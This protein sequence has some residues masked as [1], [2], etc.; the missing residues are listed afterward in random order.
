MT[1]KCKQQPKPETLGVETIKRTGVAGCPSPDDFGG[2]EPEKAKF[3]QE[4][5]S[6]KSSGEWEGCLDQFSR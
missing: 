6:E 1:V 4:N 5:C 2:E 3:P